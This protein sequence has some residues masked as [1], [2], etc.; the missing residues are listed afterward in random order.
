MFKVGQKVVC[1]SE[2][3]SKNYWTG[4]YVPNIPLP[5]VGEIYIIEGIKWNGFLFLEG[6]NLS[7]GIE[8]AGYMPINSV[9]LIFLLEKN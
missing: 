4:E 3:V 2:F 6:F 9:L 1:I 7:N 8:R 5:K